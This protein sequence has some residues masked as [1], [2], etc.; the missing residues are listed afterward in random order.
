[1]GEESNQIENLA[2]E[3]SFRAMTISSFSSVTIQPIPYISFNIRCPSVT[4]DAI[5]S[6][7]AEFMV[8]LL[9][10]SLP[11][12]SIANT[13]V[14]PH[15]P[16][17]QDGSQVLS[18]VSNTLKGF[19][20]ICARDNHAAVFCS[21]R[22]YNLPLLVSEAVMN[23]MHCRIVEEKCVEVG[24]HLVVV[25]EVLDTLNEQADE[26]DLRQNGLVYC[27]GLYMESS[28]ISQ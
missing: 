1:M 4:L 8:H 22:T 20:E 14:R 13:L 21:S 26:N 10:A 12:M 25:A 6:S 11:G 16:L 15:R 2:I 19:W 24:D 7:S 3:D 17:A 28:R 23:V 18:E 5:R 27:N 9:S